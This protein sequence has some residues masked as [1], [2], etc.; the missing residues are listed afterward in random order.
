MTCVTNR[1]MAFLKVNKLSRGT[2]HHRFTVMVSSQNVTLLL[3]RKF[4]LLENIV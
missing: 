2:H 1:D 4:K 3:L